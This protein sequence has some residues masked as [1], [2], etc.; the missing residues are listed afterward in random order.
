YYL[1][2]LSAY[3]PSCRYIH[4]IRH[5]LDMAYSSNTNQFERWGPAFNF[6]PT[7][8]SASQHLDFW[9]AVNDWVRKICTARLPGRH[10]WLRFDALCQDP[11]R[12]TERLLNFLG[13]DDAVSPELLSRIV[14]TPES[15]GRY[16]D[17]PPVF[18]DTQLQAVRDWGFDVRL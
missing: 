1:R 11:V 5:G 10:Y 13:L 12:E 17:H 7:L 2:Q 14:K 8:P 4:V 9:I 16:L 15:M 18:T 6:D 3:Y